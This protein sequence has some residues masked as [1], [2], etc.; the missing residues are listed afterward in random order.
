MRISPSSA[1]SIEVL[2]SVPE[3][4]QPSSSYSF[5]PNIV[6]A[7]TDV[8]SDA[9]YAEPVK[10]A[11]DKS[12]TNGTSATTFSPDNTCTRAQILTFLW[13]AVGS[14]QMTGANPFSDV[15]ATDYYYN[16]AL[17]ASSKGM[18]SGTTFGPNTPCTRAET[19]I[20]LW[21][22]AGCPAADQVNQFL[23]ITNINSELGK[24][25]SWA[26]MNSITGGTA[27]HSFSPDMTCTRGQIV[28]FLYR[29]LK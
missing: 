3:D 25:V 20:Y 21:K 6:G 10:W 27:A 19:V 8:L 26:F 17:W 4:N 16:A 2:V 13:R 15:N 12:I 18:I 28:T 14:P 5:K 22:N 9:W 1:P 29:A 23:D 7:F 11:V 24:A